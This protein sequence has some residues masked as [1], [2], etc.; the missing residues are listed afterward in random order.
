MQRFTISPDEALALRFDALIAA[1]GYA[2]ASQ[3]SLLICKRPLLRFF[4][5]IL[6]YLASPK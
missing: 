5:L 2:W 6:S 1:K 3:R 4:I